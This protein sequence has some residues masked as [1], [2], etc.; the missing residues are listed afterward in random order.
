MKNYLLILITLIGF[1]G[2]SQQE[3]AK[4]IT[5][6]NAENTVFTPFSVLESSAYSP[7]TA[8]N[9][10][11]EK[12]N[13]ARL[14]SSELAAIMVQKKEFIE[15]A[16]PYQNETITVQ[17]Y[18]VNPLAEGFHLDSDTQKYIAYTPGL[19]YRGAIKNNPNSVVSF[20][21]FDNDLNGIVSSNELGNV[22]VGKLENSAT[23]IVY[24]DSDLK[25]LNDFACA[26]KESATVKSS[27]VETAQPTSAR[28]VTIYFEIDFDLYEANDSNTTTTTNWMTSVFNNVQ[29]LF[30]ND[31]ISLA[32]KNI[33][34]WT[35]QDPYDG[36]GSSSSD[37][38]FKF[39]EVRPV[40]DG[41]VGQLV[42]IDPGGLGGVAVTI[43]GLCSQD[44]F[45]YSDVTTSFSS[46]PAYSWTIQVI[47]HEFGHLLGSPHTHGCYWNG[48]DTA[49]DGCGQQAG[50]SEGDC[51]QAPIP[52]SAVKGTIMSYCHLTNAGISFSNGFGPQPAALIL[53]T[54]NGSTCLS[55]DCIN[56]CINTVASI[57]VTNTDNTSATLVWAD[58]STTNWEVSASTFTAGNINWIPVS[59]NYHIFTDLA[60][61][62]FYR[63]RVR[64]VCS[65]GLEAPNRQTVVATGADYCNG[66]TLTDTGGVEA[67]YSDSETY[68]RVVIPNLPNK[69]IQLTFNSFDLELDWDYLYLYDGNST[70]ATDLSNGGF[71]GNTIPGPFESTAA[72]GSLTLKFTSD[73]FVVTP[74]Y[75]ATVAC[76]N[77]LGATGF[78][79]FI[80]FTYAPNPTTGK[81]SIQSKTAFSQLTV[82]DVMGQLLMQK[83]KTSLE[84]QLDLSGFASGTYLVSLQ[85]ESQKVHF[86]VV[87]Y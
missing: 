43:D 22:V 29:T 55:T 4:K 7:S 8:V 58:N 39:N 17:L 86:K 11:I 41:D 66:I 38:L 64:P 46:V 20:N 71:T 44:N 85:F 60:P 51:P 27:A 74:G 47:S 65:F 42:G 37:Y 32:I 56:T 83:S 14:N 80:D 5:Q 76:L 48:D 72:D 19:Y 84:D 59:I 40:F 67:D 52:S 73:G 36:I 57:A 54:V 1:A 68:V 33:F 9:A 62:T 69:K 23:Y 13:Y 16:I 2:F 35:T 6:L 82:T 87:K 77:N 3:V 25:I 21:F 81:V 12:A 75:E 10:V 26:A 31:G 79:S 63:I 18:K 30:A 49:I 15:L 34:I 61:N 45:S 24:S 78:E 28:C 53:S 70:S 50:Y